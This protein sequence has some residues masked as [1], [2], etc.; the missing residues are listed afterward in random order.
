MFGGFGLRFRAVHQAGGLGLGGGDGVGAEFGQQPAAAFG[1]QRQP[2]RIDAST[3]RVFDQ[4]VVNAL[5]ADRLVG[6]DIGDVIGALVDVGIGDQQQ[7]SRRRAFHQAARGLQHRDA[8]AF[9]PDQRAGHVEAIFGQQEVE[10]VAR[11]PAGNIGIALANQVGILI[12]EFFQAGIDFSPPAAFADDLLQFRIAGLAY[13]QTKAVVGEDIES[14]DV[15]VGLSRHDG[16]HAAGVVADHAA[17]RAAV[18]SGRVRRESQMMFLGGVA[19]VVKNHSG[20][21]PGGALPGID[22]HDVIH[23]AGEIE[24][25]GDVAA[26]SGERSSAAAAEQRSAVLARERDGGDDVIGV[27]GKNHADR[28]LAIVGAV[29]GVEGAAAGIEADVAADVLA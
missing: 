5:E 28:D 24:Y 20:L 9:G 11:N 4:Q 16:M 26:L 19:Q 27:T 3:P 2:F 15:V 21:H 13:F 1:Q 29:G 12:P 6:H 7:D 22:F 17:E 18:V 10:V 8:G 14:F 23:V 25:Q